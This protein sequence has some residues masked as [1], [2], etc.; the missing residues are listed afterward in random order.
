MLTCLCVRFARSFVGTA[1]L[2]V[3]PGTRQSSSITRCAWTV[4]VCALQIVCVCVCVLVL[5]SLPPAHAL[6]HTRCP[7][8]LTSAA[9]FGLRCRLALESVYVD[10]ALNAV[11][12]IPVAPPSNRAC[13]CACVL[14]C[15]C[16]SVCVCACVL[17][18]AC[19]SVC[20]CVRACVCE[21][22]RVG[23]Y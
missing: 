4:S 17:T 3:E 16:I 11:L 19:I 5:T 22:V 21:C 6:S 2:A 7:L 10:A 14:T 12:R 1:Y 9:C 20:V 23:V 18:C 13:M 8:H 15:A